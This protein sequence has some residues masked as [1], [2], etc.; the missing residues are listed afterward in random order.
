MSENSY[1]QLENSP[2]NRTL[3]Y[4]HYYHLK[5][6]PFE[7]YPQF[8]MY[9]PIPHW[10]QN[11]KYLQQF[12]LGPR[13]LLLIEGEFGIGKSMLLAQFLTQLSADVTAYQLKGR[14]SITPSQLIAELAQGFQLPLTLSQPTL[15]EQMAAEIA[16]LQRLQKTCLLVIDDADLLPAETLVTLITLAAAQDQTRINLYI[17]LAC[18]LDLQSQ[19]E[20]IAREQGYAIYFPTLALTPLNLEETKNYIKHRLV[21]AGLTDK[22]PF[23]KEMLMYIHELSAGIPGRINRIAQQLLI[24]LLKPTAERL[25]LPKSEQA[26]FLLKKGSIKITSLLMVL[27]VISGIVFFEMQRPLHV[28]ASNPVSLPLSIPIQHASLPEVKQANSQPPQELRLAEAEVIA[29]HPL[30]MISELHENNSSSTTQVVAPKPIEEINTKPIEKIVVSDNSSS[31]TAAEKKLLVMQG[32]TLQ[33]MGSRRPSDLK[34]FINRHQLSDAHLMQFRTEYLGKPWYVLVYGNY[35][36]VQ[37]AKLAVQQL[38]KTVRA[39]HPW[40][41]PMASVHDAIKQKM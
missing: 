26:H 37:N 17:L 32:Y 29:G 40:I 19:L 38:P 11:L 28:T 5:Q 13:P 23:T 24:D 14:A 22:M 20:N 21:K 18:E 7:D 30:P 36:D 15:Q 4:W 9:F 10:Q 12:C 27:M 8:A 34:R 16:T 1:E 3:N 41:R 31:L 2:L 25:P 39:M 35:Q 33:V 6:S